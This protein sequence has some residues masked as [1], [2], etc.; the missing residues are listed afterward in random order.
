MC[1]LT[2]IS[3]LFLPSSLIYLVKAKSLIVKKNNYIKSSN[4]HLYLASPPLPQG[5]LDSVRFCLCIFFLFH[6]CSVCIVTIFPE[7]WVTPLVTPPQTLQWC[8]CLWC[9]YLPRALA[10]SML[11]TDSLVLFCDT[12]LSSSSFA[13]KSSCYNQNRTKNIIIETERLFNL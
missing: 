13:K 5:T 10:F 12:S 6:K 3:C 7:S 9:T 2:F 8:W 4:V 1:F 11:S